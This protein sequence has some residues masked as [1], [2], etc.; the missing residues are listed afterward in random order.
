[1]SANSASAPRTSWQDQLKAHCKNH[2]L[3]APLFNIYTE[4]RGGRTA[5]TCVASVQGRQYPAQFWYDGNYVNNA[6][7]D[8]AEKA[9]NV[10]S[11]QPSR[12]NTSYPGQMYVC[13]PR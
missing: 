9:L 6:K 3:D 8:A 5:W 7:E 2:K 13:P 12:N 10:L 1:M 11:P 4:R